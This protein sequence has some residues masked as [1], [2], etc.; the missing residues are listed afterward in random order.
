MNQLTLQSDFKDCYDYLCSDNGV[1]VYNRVRDKSK[2][3]G[4]LLKYLSSIGI[5]T[6]ELKPVTQFLNSDEKIVVYTDPFA[7]DGLGKRVMSIEEARMYNYNCVASKYYT[8]NDMINIK[9]LQIGKRRFNIY[10]KKDEQYTLERGHI[11]DITESANEYNSLIALPI[12]SIDYISNGR[13]MIA[14]DFNDVENISNLGIGSLI[15]DDKII[16]EIVESLTIYK[17]T[18]S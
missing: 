2:Q 7:H 1:K 15:S 16:D 12:F 6:L 11:V 10:F 18:K 4:S 3:R 9:Y 8:S 17:N 13:E 5:K 14:T